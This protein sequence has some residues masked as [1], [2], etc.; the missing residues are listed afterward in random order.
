MGSGSDDGLLGVA[1]RGG[2]PAREGGI[3]AMI[4]SVVC[5]G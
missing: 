4:L 2:F 5:G 3:V 1:E